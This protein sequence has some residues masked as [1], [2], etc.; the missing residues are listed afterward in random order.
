MSY[1]QRRYRYG[2]II[3]V[4][5][6]HTARCGAPGQP[7][8]EKVRLTPEAVRKQN[9]RWKEEQTARIIGA[10]FVEDD[11]VRTLTFARDKRPGSMKEAQTIFKKFY[12]RL[13]REYRK[14]YYELFWLANIECTPRGAWH[15]HFICNAIF[16]ASDIIRSLWEEYGGTY[17]QKLKD[18]TGAGKN[19]GAYMAKTPDSTKNKGEH[20]VS[21]SKST[22][23]RNLI[24]PEPEEKTITGWSMDDAPR[25]P[26]G[27]Y[28]IKDSLYEGISEAGYRYRGYKFARIK[29]KPPRDR[30][31]KPPARGRRRK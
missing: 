5:E 2:N 10:N 8:R 13:R 24:I 26:R 12:E 18:L 22:H 30:R 21:E 29:P 14:R 23:S 25:P 15:I 19:L 31:Y 27:Y 7:R 20:E 28:L 11:L 3:E 6:S 1:R 9:Q 17:D 16:G 4:R